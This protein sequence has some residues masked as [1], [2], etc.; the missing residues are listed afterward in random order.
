MLERNAKLVQKKTYQ[1]LIPTIIM[2]IA[3]QFGSVLDGV[4]IGNLI[5]ADALAAS[6]LALPILYLIQIPGLAL[7]IGAAI[8][9]STL[10]GKREIDQ[11]SKIFS[12]I[13][14][15]GFIISIIIAVLG[16][17]ISTPIAKLVTSG[18]PSYTAMAKDYIFIYMVTIPVITLAIIFANVLPADNNPNLASIYFILANIIKV[19]TE[20][21]YIKIL[22]LGLIG[23]ALSTA[24]GYLVGIIILIFYIKSKNRLL[25][26]TFNFK[27]ILKDFI[28]TL[29]A[30]ASTAMSYAL[31]TIQYIVLAIFV[32][33]YFND[34]EIFTYAIIANLIFIVDLFIGGIIFITPSICGIL[35]GDKD[36][37]AL[38]N[39]TKRL[40][41]I[42]IIISI[43]LSIVIAVFPKSMFIIF[44]GSDVLY[45]E[46]ALNSV[47]I[48]TICFIFY[49]LTRFFLSY[50][51]SVEKSGLS[52][53]ITILRDGIIFIPT[54]IILIIILKRSVSISYTYIISTFL[55][56]FITFMIIL[57]YQKV[58]NKKISGIFF[59]PK[60]DKQDEY[61]FTIENKLSSPG[62]VSTE[63]SHYALTHNAD[64][65]SAQLIGLAGEEIC[66]NIIEYGYKKKKVSY[67]DI[68]L[69]ILE[70]SKLILRI[71]DD[72]IA[73]D[74][75]LI[76]EEDVSLAHIGINLI[77]KTADE[78]KYLRLLNTNNTII[79]IQIGGKKDDN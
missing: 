62:I 20:I 63:L 56:L 38:K 60:I 44:G 75:T 77:K 71:R 11:A 8:I 5:S 54:S 26:F 49:G 59:I 28:N 21:L 10:L 30:S 18:D 67:I 42:L 76:K 70:N 40:L 4:L 55:S 68:N 79:E 64:N 69:K 19:L 35:Y 31:M 34:V 15:I 39:I 36:Y 78:F 58:K 24:S 32:T 22:N 2:V 66:L 57:I 48:F 52:L 25:H 43:T 50:Y 29:K 9:I 45:D 33:K 65:R 41:L 51:P 3:M 53:L 46:V 6:S 61:D 27:G 1:Y 16:L 13:I 72:G 17:F 23:A 74:P 7:G 14:L 12:F 37:F 73:Y 47:R